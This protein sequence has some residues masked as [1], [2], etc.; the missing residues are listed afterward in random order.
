[1][2]KNP[3]ISNHKVTFHIYRYFSNSAVKCEQSTI[4]RLR[5]KEIKNSS[6]K[7]KSATLVDYALLVSDKF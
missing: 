1:M 3:S 6:S 5:F 4:S 7:G 2:I